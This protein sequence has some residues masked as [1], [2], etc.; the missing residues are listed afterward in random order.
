MRALADVNRRR[1]NPDIMTGVSSSPNHLAKPTRWMILLVL[2]TTGCASM[3]F[4]ANSSLWDDEPFTGVYHRIGG[5]SFHLH[6]TLHAIADTADLSEVKIVLRES[7]DNVRG[8]VEM[9]GMPAGESLTDAA[10]FYERVVLS[11]FKPRHS[12]DRIIDGRPGRIIRA[13]D[14]AGGFQFH[15]FSIRGDALLHA[16]YAADTP[17]AAIPG[18]FVELT[19]SLRFHDEYKLECVRSDL[20]FTLRDLSGRWRLSADLPSG[21]LTAIRT[22]NSRGLY[23]W[24]G[25]KDNPYIG[26]SESEVEV[27]PAETWSASTE[28]DVRLPTEIAYRGTSSPLFVL[29]DDDRDTGLATILGDELIVA[30]FSLRMYTN[31]KD[32]APQRLY[33]FL[34]EVLEWNIEP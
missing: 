10:L 31:W 26:T 12:F 7:S 6:E 2:F 3:Q 23:L 9:T 11:D 18:E 25:K 4:K 29:R 16:A 30:M 17:D 34:S 32:F 24:I 28:S 5:L 14:P 15:F 1:Y 21:V 20:G 27:I 8:F 22:E 33:D 13:A 19:S